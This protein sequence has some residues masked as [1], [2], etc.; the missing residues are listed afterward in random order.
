[1]WIC[2]GK[3]RRGKTSNCR[4]YNIILVLNIFNVIS[5]FSFFPGSVAKSVG[6]ASVAAAG[7]AALVCAPCFGWVCGRKGMTG[8]CRFMSGVAEWH[9]GV[10]NM[11]ATDNYCPDGGIR[12]AGRCP[13]DVRSGKDLLFLN[14]NRLNDTF[15]KKNKKKE[16]YY[17][18]C[19]EELPIF[20]ETKSRQWK[21]GILNIGGGLAQNSK[22]CEGVSHTVC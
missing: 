2:R 3:P 13:K 12:P 22:G 20:A 6:G 9:V 10:R 1:M 17:C 7:T 15:L 4:F 18:C 5:P 8:A 11:A 16:L 21:C 19:F 14:E